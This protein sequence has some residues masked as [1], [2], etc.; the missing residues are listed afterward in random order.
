MLVL[1]AP[2]AQPQWILPS[3]KKPTQGD[4]KRFLTGMRD[5][6]AF[7]R[8]QVQA[9]NIGADQFGEEFY[10]LL[11]RGHSDAWRL[12]KN[13]AGDF[14]DNPFMDA[15]TG[16]GVADGEAEFIHGFINRISNGFYQTAE[17]EWKEKLFQSHVNLYVQKT[18]GT[19]NEAFTEAS[20]VE[21]EF[22]WVLG[23]VEKH[24]SDCPY[25]ASLN[26]WKKDE[27]VTNPGQGETQCLGHCK[28]HW[29]RDDGQTSFKPVSLA[30]AA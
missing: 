29:R 20:P 21:A 5:N 2:A 15:L 3:P 28:C 4:F 14:T 8:Q 1:K 19:A 24:C 13:R 26:P 18:R 17:G 12:G 27:I 30:L 10:N 9:G 22:D 6:G 25:F 16:R 11:R 7:L 23:A